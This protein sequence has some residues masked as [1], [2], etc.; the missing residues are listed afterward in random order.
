MKKRLMFAL[1]AGAIAIGGIAYLLYLGCELGEWRTWLLDDGRC[2][3]IAEAY[4][5]SARR[6]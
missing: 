3:G 4:R 2:Q 1:I 6:R 5:E